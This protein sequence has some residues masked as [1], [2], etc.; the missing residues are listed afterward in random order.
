MQK[1]VNKKFK[2]HHFEIIAIKIW[3]YFLVFYIV[4]Y[5]LV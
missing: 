1:K 5:T 2:S 4:L 3:M